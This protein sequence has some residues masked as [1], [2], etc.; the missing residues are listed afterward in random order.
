MLFR[1]RQSWFDGEKYA[2]TLQPKEVFAKFLLAMLGGF[3]LNFMPCVLPVIGLKIL[4]FVN[5]AHG[6][7]RTASLLTLIYSA[8]MIAVLLGFGMTSLGLR[9]MTGRAL[10]WGALF[11]NTATQVLFTGFMFTL[12]LSFLGVWEFPIPGFATGAKSTELSNRK[13]ATGAF[14]KGVITTLLATPCSGPFLGSVLAV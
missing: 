3:I 13:G 7:R 10:E 8:G 1:S 2:L 11:G 4:G 6:D 5:E 12:A 14:F 9:W